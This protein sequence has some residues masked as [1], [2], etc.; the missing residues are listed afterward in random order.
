[1]DLNLDWVVIHEMPDAVIRNAPALRPLA[2]RPDRWL[3]VLGED[4]TQSQPSYIGELSYDEGRCRS[5]HTYGGASTH[6]AG[7]TWTGSEASGVT[8]GLP[9]AVAL[10]LGIMAKN[11]SASS[12]LFKSR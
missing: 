2:Q 12:L 11:C 9:V 4:P 5:V 10:S 1:M 6:A 8:L 7:W 3:L